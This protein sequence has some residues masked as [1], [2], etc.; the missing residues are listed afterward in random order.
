MLTKASFTN[1]TAAA[2][3]PLPM[4]GANLTGPLLTLIWTGSRF[5]DRKIR[6]FIGLSRT[7]M[8]ASWQLPGTD[9]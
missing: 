5:K 9:Y 3:G 7:R 6:P 4:S 1:F 2:V 8:C